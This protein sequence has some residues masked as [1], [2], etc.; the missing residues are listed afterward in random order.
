[1]SSENFLKMHIDA[2]ADDIG[3]RELRKE[4]LHLS[5]LHERKNSD[6]RRRNEFTGVCLSGNQSGDTSNPNTSVIYGEGVNIAIKARIDGVDTEI[7]PHLCD[8][9][10]TSDQ[11][12]RFANLHPTPLSSQG[13]SI[14]KRPPRFGDKLIFKC[15]GNS[16]DYNGQMRQLRYEL[17]SSVEKWTMECASGYAAASSFFGQG[18]FWT[19]I[20]EMQSSFTS[21]GAGQ[22]DYDPNWWI[23][24]LEK[25]IALGADG[26]KCYWGKRYD[27]V[28]PVDGR[29]IIGIAHWTQSSLNPLVDEMVSVIGEETVSSWFGRSSEKLKAFNSTCNATS[30]KC[31][32]VDWWKAGWEKFVKHPKTVEIQRVVWKRKYADETERWIAKRGWPKT[33]RNMAII[34][35]CWN[36]G[37]RGGVNIWSDYGK[38]TP[39]ETARNYM[40]GSEKKPP[41]AKLDKHREKRINAID[42]HFPCGK[43]T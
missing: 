33:N 9:T 10:Y 26:K 14:G 7:I 15:Y 34:A 19:T 2:L 32:Y 20:K 29:G 30:N 17:P 18:E 41:R 27:E 8:S 21:C 5:A 22:P 28:C 43:G 24:C 35:G 42:K 16:T 12:K 39:E 1:M 4:L 40:Y 37:G 23:V 11:L 6:L 38:N 13:F 31:F 36:S 25:V 3:K